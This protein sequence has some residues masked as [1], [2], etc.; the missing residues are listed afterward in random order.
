MNKLLAQSLTIPWFGGNGSDPKVIK[1]ENIG[2]QSKYSNIADILSASMQLI[3]VFGG[4]GL[5]LMLL[6]GGFT[7]L[8]SAGD[9]KKLQQGQQR[10]TNAILGLIIIFIAFW[11]VQAL[12]LIFG[13][14][15]ITETIFK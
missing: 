10:I 15:A 7:L 8:T 13:I 1:L 11:L 4:I 12:G 6:A 14:D 5:L 9:P 3:F 2:I